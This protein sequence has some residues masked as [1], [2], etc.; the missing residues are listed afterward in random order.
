M[1]GFYRYVNYVKQQLSSNNRLEAFSHN[2][3]NKYVD[4]DFA[5]NPYAVLRTNRG[6]VH[7]Y[8][9]KEAGV[10]S[11]DLVLG[12]LDGSRVSTQNRRPLV[13]LPDHRKDCFYYNEVRWNPSTMDGYAGHPEEINQRTLPGQFVKYPW[14]TV[15][16][17]LEP[18]IIRL[19]GPLDTERFRA[20]PGHNHGRDLQTEV[21]D[22][23]LP[24]KPLFFQY[25]TWQDLF[26]NLNGKPM[27]GMKRSA[28]D[29]DVEVTLRL[30]IGN[31]QEIIEMRRVYK[32]GGIADAMK[33]QGAVAQPY[34]NLA[35]IPDL[36][37]ATY[38][39][40]QVVVQEQRDPDFPISLSMYASWDNE[41]GASLTIVPGDKL[42]PI[43]RVDPANNNMEGT[44]VYHP[45]KRF[46]M[47][48]VN[49]GDSTG[50][51]IFLDN[52][53]QTNEEVSRSFDLA[54]D[55]G[56]TNTHVE[57]RDRAGGRYETFSLENPGSS[58]RTL[59]PYDIIPTLDPLRTNLLMRSF[60]H[61]IGNGGRYNFPIRT[62]I[63]ESRA[64]IAP[65][66]M[67]IARKNIPFYYLHEK[68]P[69]PDEIFT[70]LKWSD[71]K[72]ENDKSRLHHFIH[73]IV[74]IAAY[75]IV[76]RRG[77]LNAVR[78]VYF[79]PSS[80][81]MARQV[82]LTKAWK[83]AYS[84]YFG[85]SNNFIQA[86]SES[87]AP[88][89]YFAKAEKHIWKGENTINCDIGG[90]TCDAYINYPNHK[91]TPKIASF[92]FGGNA[93]FGDG[94]DTNKGKK[95]GFITA[96]RD[97]VETRLENGDS[98]DHQATRKTY[99]QLMNRSI[100]SEEVIS[101]YLSL[102]NRDLH[103][104]VFFDFNEH[105]SLNKPQ[106]KLIYLVY[107]GSIV[108][109]LLQVTKSMNLDQPTDISFTG[110]GS[111]IIQTLANDKTLS[112][113]ANYIADGVYK[114]KEPITGIRI[115]TFEQPKEYTCKGG[116]ALIAETQ[117]L[118]TDFTPP[119]NV[120][121]LGTDSAHSG[122]DMHFVQE[123]GRIVGSAPT[124]SEL[125]SD[126]KFKTA[127]IKEVENFIDLLFSIN[128]KFSFKR[129][130]NLDI[131]DWEAAKAAIK[132]D[133]PRGYSNGLEER[134]KESHVNDAAQETLFFHPLRN[135]IYN[136]S[137]TLANRKI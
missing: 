94:Y 25:F 88:Y 72:A 114:N 71:M 12:E 63:A 37:V 50:G 38:A 2:L 107:F 61:E 100:S 41:I 36:Q 110:N 108:Y 118:N 116:L 131:K 53:R 43:V 27:L 98:L 44:M 55:F 6:Q 69:K 84:K 113:I 86:L 65:E 59:Y 22:Y 29:R 40:G 97:A 133:L 68:S 18:T 42:D 104:E 109:H 77:D 52:I 130:L 64:T 87:V 123:G 31:S 17:F 81:E 49:A 105:V 11:S 10:D 62:A 112:I 7:L 20:N 99:Q 82:E 3:V 102:V 60:Y 30:P 45:K 57:I 85:I 47:I 132:D 80:M 67:P 9:Q 39:H 73:A 5:S 74:Q 13:L 106:M 19:P 28:D 46:D 21:G 75:E 4:R 117:D 124:Y 51:W 79:F 23:L 103:Q 48:R 90:G 76:A 56:T 34:L 15:S 120:V 35:L 126:P 78:L 16:D 127:A 1:P 115:V 111:K 136:L 93:V 101:F 33:N 121:V 66:I 58:L 134:I 8:G 96:V 54:V 24:I 128:K 89:Q 26:S 14:V 122:K 137:M 125:Q 92:R 91:N 119:Q 83:E 135:A 70:N 32:K 95:N 129:N